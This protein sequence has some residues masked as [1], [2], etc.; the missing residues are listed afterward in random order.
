MSRVRVG[1]IGMGAMGR[2]HLRAWR[3]IGE[4]DVI[5]VV[6]SRPQEG[7]AV[8][9]TVESLLA[10]GQPDLVSVCTPTD[11]HPA[12]VRELL[13]AGCDVVCEKPLALT[14]VEAA[15]LFAEAESAGR[16]LAVGHVVRHFPQYSEVRAIL[17]SGRL[18]TPAT[19]RLR[20]AVPWPAGASDWFSDEARS[21]GVVFDLMI[22]DLDFLVGEWG[23]PETVFARRADGPGTSMVTATMRF[24]EGV[25]AHVEALWGGVTELEYSCEIAGSEGSV[26]FSSRRS[27]GMVLTSAITGAM[28]H[29]SPTILDPYA[30]QLRHLAEVRR[31]GTVATSD[32]QTIETI[33][34]CEMIGRSLQ[35]RQSV[36]AQGWGKA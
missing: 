32:Q 33:M 6:S 25:L 36:S 24:P 2:T 10:H 22:H 35:T 19:A 16:M 4:A 17:D 29:E 28:R 5:G 7:V 34:T 26:E 27:A 30:A 9:E 13:A 15:G 3:S 8:Y 21:G 14:A 1:V 20:R 12:I 31:A 23:R 18:G 11:T